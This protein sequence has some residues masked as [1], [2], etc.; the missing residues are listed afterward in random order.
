MSRGARNRLERND[1]LV[2]L[3]LLVVAFSAVS[4]LLV[5][6]VFIIEQGTPIMLKYGLKS[7][8]A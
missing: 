6:T 2:R 4:A 1:R 7:F 5:I 3:A 8:L